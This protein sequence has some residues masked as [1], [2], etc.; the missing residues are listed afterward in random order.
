MPMLSGSRL[1]LLWMKRSQAQQSPISPARRH[2][3]TRAQA[4]ANSLTLNTFT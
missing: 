4:G 2:Y 1:S 3:F